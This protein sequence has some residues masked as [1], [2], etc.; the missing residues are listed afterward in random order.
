MGEMGKKTPSETFCILPFVHLEAR[1]LGTVNSC[2]VGSKNFRTQSG[3]ELDLR[4]HTIDEAWQSP[5]LLRLRAELLQGKKPK[6]CYQ[7]W[8]EEAAGRQSKRLQENL[9]YQH[10][11]ES[12]LPERGLSENHETVGIEVE[13]ARPFEQPVSLDLKLGTTCNLQCRMCNVEKSS[14]WQAEAEATGYRSAN[15]DRARSHGRWADD[16]SGFWHN[17]HQLAPGLERAEFYGGEPFLNRP[18][19]EFLNRCVASGEA[20][21]IKLVYCTNGTVFPEKTATQVWPKFEHVT[22]GLSIDAVG[23]R[24][25]YQRFPA[26]FAEIENNVHRFAALTGVNVYIIATIN[27]FSL[28]YL[29]ELAE[30][31]AQMDLP[32]YLN[33]L[34][35]PP[36]YNVRN[37]PEAIKAQIVQRFANWQH[38]SVNATELQAILRY[39]LQQ[40]ADIEIQREFLAVTRRSDA[41]RGTSFAH[42]FPE[43]A[44]AYQEALSPPI[45]S[46]LQA[47][48]SEKNFPG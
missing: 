6:N 45:T 29:D 14:K 23:R 25:E 2:C 22:V 37:Y 38:V 42:V 20:G 28:F 46:H 3:E 15:L 16:N 17:L 5:D 36:I 12:V 10:L 13:Q 27:V 30:F 34:H 26:R 8:D 11:F 4:K 35:G 47:Q 48:S 39:M 24:L 9:R 44:A 18:H 1:Q 31:A 40:S 32:I 41:Y 7:C 19:F 43:L 21:H 33:L